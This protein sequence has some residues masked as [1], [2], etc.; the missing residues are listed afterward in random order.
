MSGS[1]SA[2]GE[3]TS[4]EGEGVAA[5][6]VP[7]TTPHGV[8][9]TTSGARMMMQHPWLAAAAV[10]VYA[11]KVMWVKFRALGLANQLGRL[12]KQRVRKSDPWQDNAE[13]DSGSEAETDSD[14]EEGDSD[15]VTDNVELGLKLSVNRDNDRLVNVPPANLS[16]GIC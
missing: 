7:D 6:P 8:D 11:T 10:A 4:A 16:N 15:E 14:C 9:A 13:N 3:G 2:G 12:Q 1:E 5:A